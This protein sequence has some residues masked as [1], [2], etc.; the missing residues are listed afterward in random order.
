MN[1]G[2][3]VTLF[4]FS[5]SSLVDAWHSIDDRV[6]GGIS[7]SQL[8]AVHDYAVFEGYVSAENNGGFASIR[9]SLPQAILADADNLCLE[10]RGQDKT[11]QV[12]VRTENGFDGLSYR[13]GFCPVSDWARHSV[14][15]VEFKPV[16]RGRSV[17][18]APQLVPANIRQIGLMVTDRQW[19]AFAIDIRKIG[20]S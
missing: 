3:A 14:P 15:F 7:R 5:D 4:D 20:V 18:D 8:R 13:T 1:R 6:M 17:P 2:V 10:M 9:A 16:F 19:G 11:L 12:N